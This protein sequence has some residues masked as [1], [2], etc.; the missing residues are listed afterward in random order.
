MCLKCESA[1]IQRRMH[2]GTSFGK[3]FDVAD[4]RGSGSAFGCHVPFQLSPDAVDDV[5]T[6]TERAAMGRS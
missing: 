5:L 1:Y 2:S 3:L 6:T 4:G